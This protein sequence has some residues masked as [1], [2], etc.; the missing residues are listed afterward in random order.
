MTENKDIPK[1]NFFDLAK[2]NELKN[3]VKT[4]YKKIGSINNPALKA[5][6]IFNSDGLHHL[7]YDRQR[8][9]RSKPAQQNK[10]RFFNDAVNTIKNATTIQEYRRNICSIGEPDKS[11]FRKTTT[12]EFFAFWTIISFIKKIRIRVVIRRIG[13][14]NGQFHFWSVMPFWSLNNKQRIIGSREIEDE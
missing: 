1:T 2:F 7:K 12:M 9:E 8:S 5:R 6:V 3:S 13:G 4:G 11:G 14:D 10:F